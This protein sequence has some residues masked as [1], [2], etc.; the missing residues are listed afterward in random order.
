ML[1][2]PEKF[3]AMTI[4]KNC[5]NPTETN[6]FHIRDTDITPE[7]VVKRFG[8]LL[9]HKVSFNEHISQLCCKASRQFNVFRRIGSFFEEA[10]RLLIYKCFI[11]SHFDVNN[12]AWEINP[13][14]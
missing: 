10:T 6:E 8:V 1:A 5:Q 2:N 3:Q 13:P 7:P 14:I 11:K 9:D 12:K 4:Q